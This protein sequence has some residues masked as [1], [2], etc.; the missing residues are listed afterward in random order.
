[1]AKKGKERKKEVVI[2]FFCLSSCSMSWELGFMTS[3]NILSNL[4]QLEDPWTS[5]D[6]VG[7]PIDCGSDK[8]ARSIGN[9]LACDWHLSLSG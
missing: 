1:M 9:N 5:M 3:E 8:S 7:S 6:L 4:C 2:V